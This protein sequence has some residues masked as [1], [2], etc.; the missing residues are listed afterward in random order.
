MMS[1]PPR[2]NELSS[3]L[4]FKDCNLALYKIIYKVLKRYWMN[5]L[6]MLLLMLNLRYLNSSETRK[7]KKETVL[8]LTQEFHKHNCKRIA[9]LQMLQF[10][11]I[12]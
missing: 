11:K 9:L 8:D 1:P 6:R 4:L 7:K 12:F 10:S 5:F 3:G 2:E